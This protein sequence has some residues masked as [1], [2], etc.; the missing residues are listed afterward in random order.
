M[1]A[2]AQNAFLKM[3]EEPPHYAVFL[4]LCSNTASLLDTIKSR[5]P[6]LYTEVL[7]QSDVRAYLLEHSPRAREMA[8]T[9]PSRL[10][11]VLL[12]A[13][14]SIG[15]AMFLCEDAEK[16]DAEKNLVYALL[17]ALTAPAAAGIGMLCDALPTASDALCELLDMLKRAFRDIAVLQKA[18]TCTPLF[19]E[20][21]DRAET[22]TMK[23]TVAKAI[24]LV[25]A[26]DRLLADL[27]LNMDT[28]LAAVSLIGDMRTIMMN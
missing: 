23:I 3:L 20:R 4:L 25:E 17:D 19:F 7:P 27:R 11:S 2:S 12:S 10:T 9:D 16:Y 15:N 1:N 5:A 13:G 24:A 28:R 6:V 8:A 14:G 18:P 26:V 22:Y 21:A